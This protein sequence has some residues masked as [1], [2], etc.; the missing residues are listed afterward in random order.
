MQTFG[1]RPGAPPGVMPPPP[2][3]IGAP[4]GFPG[5][6]GVP[7]P[8]P[9]GYPP[10]MAP[11]PGMPPPPG[12]VPA[13]PLSA[14]FGAMN[15]GPPG[16]PLP[17]GGAP[18]P[19][20]LPVKPLG[21]AP[22]A[23]SFPPGPPGPGGMPPMPA[24]LS[25]RGMPP[26][27]PG[28]FPPGPPG[29]GSMPPGPPGMP[30]PSDGLQQ[31]PSAGF[32]PGP[33]GPPGAGPL[34]PGSVPLSLPNVPPPSMHSGG[35]MGVPPVQAANG[36]HPAPPSGA[37]PPGM[38]GAPPPP[39]MPGMPG[40]MPPPG[41]PG[42]PGGPPPP[43]GAFMPPPPGMPMGPPPPTTMAPPQHAP[44]QRPAVPQT[45]QASGGGPSRIDPTQIPRPV[46]QP[47]ST[48][49]L[50]FDTRMAGAHA[51]PPPASSRFIVRDRG[52]CSPRYVRATLN[53][54]PH[55]PELLSNCAMPLAL[56]VSPLALPDPGDDP[57]QMVDVTEA[58]PIR[59]GRC[60]AYMNPWVRWTG[61]G[62]SYT[63]NFCG[64]SNTTPD[65][66]FC[67]LGPDGR[68]RDADER[69]ELC[70]GTVEY[71]ASKEYAF[72]PP[73][74]PAHVFLIDVSAAAISSGATASLCRAVATALDRIQ[75]GSRALVGIA[76]FDTSVHFYSLRS[77][78]STPQMLV[79]SDVSDVFA[80]ASGKLLM[81][82]EAHAAQLKELLE[83]LPGMWANNRVNDN[84]AGAAIEAAIDLLKPY[85]GKVHAFV[86]SLPSVGVHALKQRDAANIG[87][88]DKLT[89]LT[90][91][92]N[93]LRSLAATAADHN[94]AVDLVVLSQAYCDIASL[95]DLATTTGGTVYSYA[96][97][98]A[99]ADFDQLVNDLSWNVA[100][101][102]GLEAVMRVRCSN[103]LD[104][105]SYS[106]H[107]Y[108]PPNT[109]DVFLPAIDCD[110]ALLAKLVLTEKL[111]AGSEC[112]VQA[113]LLYT[114][115][116]GQRVIRVHTLALP[117][118]DNISTVFK[119]AD[120]D[121][122]ICTLG[123]RVASALLGQQ[124]LGACREMVSSTVVATLYGYRRYCA[125]SSSAVQLILPE[126][127]KLLPLYALSLLKSAGLKDNVKP[128]DRALWITR[129][130]CLPCSRVGPLL[131]PR[132]LPLARLL[133][134]A[135]EDNA[136]AADGNTFEGQTLSSES[137]EAGGV[138]LLENGYE[139]ILYIDRG[140][141]GQLLYDLLGVASHDDLSRVPNLALLPRDSWPSRLLQD[142][143]TK[144][145]LQRSSFMR[146]RV[147][148][149]GDPAESAFFN[150][151]VEDRSTAGMSYVE[152]LCQIH[153]LIQ[154]KM[155]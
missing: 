108:R 72:R 79:M 9:G 3:G 20:G 84:C 114:N 109:P 39:P 1:P 5:P 111:A 6:P 95:A 77:P 154:N 53:H 155:A 141:S 13:A 149:K 107:C 117:V 147:A 152:Y 56:V 120:L 7:P 48:E 10:A 106:G 82:V 38:Y 25:T 103:G 21:G 63:C 130:G 26:P 58:G 85:G 64:L 121:A 46:A 66:Y 35:L 42:A 146:L 37:A 30:P 116:A 139:A 98:N 151:L 90:S 99:L 89:Y 4:V 69:P 138:S 43:P 119:G 8:G 80:P 83:G 115:V 17:P 24:G 29:P 123:R 140:A 33:P 50:V 145:R 76:T 118:T 127:L 71:L 28:G 102:Q 94:V 36:L 81:E 2:G 153:R 11:P 135:R 44:P 68:R 91:Q 34:G 65:Y 112:Y 150:M 136:T 23:P 62:R 133:S 75:G 128:D 125:A 60:K 113:A 110:K 61:S 59:C 67:H 78:S 100:R 45:P 31:R 54:V 19:G 41:M 16:M 88:K 40:G 93:T 12:G 15:L 148:R 104:V 49:L 129:M 142:L 86:A 144:I 27:P 122:Q 137:L 96:P 134:E 70:R 14:S 51:V 52:S 18:V 74:A 32:P 92:D 87:E 101:Q 132:L 97:Y 126:A 105:E 143:L 131:Y 73:M 55:S 47:S 22:A 124:T 57:I